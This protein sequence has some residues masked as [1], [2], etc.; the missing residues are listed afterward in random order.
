[1]TKDVTKV[2]GLGLVGAASF[3]LGGVALADDVQNSSAGP[4]AEAPAQ[5]EEVT[6]EAVAAAKADLD[7]TNQ[8]LTAA[9]SDV[10]ASKKEA[11]DAEDRLTQAE[12]LKNQAT[13]EAIVAAENKVT[14]LSQQVTDLQGANQE[15]AEAVKTQSETVAQAQNALAGAQEAQ[16]KA[17]ADVDALGLSDVTTKRDQ[18]Q[19]DVT[20]QGEALAQA[21]NKLEAAKEADN[22]RQADLEE[23]QETA[24]ETQ[25]QVT[26]SKTV[27]DD[28]TAKATQTQDALTTQQQTLDKATNDYDSINTITLTPEYIQAL[29]GLYGLYDRRSDNTEG[30]QQTLASLA[31]SLDANNVYKA[32]P[33]DDD[34]TLYDINNLPQDVITELS[35]FASDL[36]NQVRRQM[37]TPKTIVTPSSIQFAD[38]VTDGYVEDNFSMWKRAWHDGRAVNSA[39][40]YF[41]LPTSS[42]EDEA[43]GI[44]YYENGA[45]TF[46]GKQASLATLKMQV[47]NAIK[48]LLFSKTEWMHAQSIAGLDYGNYD[49]HN[50]EAFAV[51]FSNV[52]DPYSSSH[53]LLISSSDLAK[54][55]KN[56]FDTTALANPYDSEAITKAYQDAKRAYDVAKTADDSAKAALA[57]AQAD[58]D[59]ANLAH[60]DASVKLTQLQETPLQTPAAQATVTALTDKLAASQKLLADLEAQLADLSADLKA[61]V[62]K[63]DASKEATAA[64]KTQLANELAN[65]AQVKAHYEQAEKDLKASQEALSQAKT[66]LD[67]LSHATENYEQARTDFELSLEK[68]QLS[69]A[70]YDKLAEAQKQAQANYD[71]LAN[72]YEKL[73][74]E[75]RQASL[76]AK[77]DAIV[78]KGGA[79]VAVVDDSG[80]VVDYVDGK[81]NQVATDKPSTASAKVISTTSTPEK[82]TYSRV[83]KSTAQ[84]A[85]LPTTG[86]TSSALVVAFGGLLTAFGLA[87]TRRK[88]HQ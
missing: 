82:V 16:D 64:A 35:L 23:A 79:P 15:A 48:L 47:Y 33:N 44:Q 65:L 53:F 70:T 5:T 49:R 86:D 41:G 46:A 72:R 43:E 54:A 83:A 57:T 19:A 1:M 84:K 2:V 68:L 9:T 69:V 42:K 36:I 51:D 24:T 80:R 85:S 28:A 12:T 61:K 66:L 10:V 3:S 7:A 55:T 31:D 17:Q 11:E 25:T 40:R 4:A 50:Y 71:T 38:L 60:Q 78:A 63:L 58:Y 8:A 21:K 13:P 67:D 39:A 26:T 87:G 14:D 62:A 76:K 73:Q 52:S 20:S 77:R 22:K 18:A 74:E 29:H 30:L 27:L 32:N 37:G 56:N 88:R 45:G 59:A 81:D 75:K 34:K 6:A